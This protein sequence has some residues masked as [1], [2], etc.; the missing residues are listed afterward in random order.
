MGGKVS[1]FFF[2]LCLFIFFVCR[3]LR[4]KIPIKVFKYDITRLNKLHRESLIEK[5]TRH[6]PKQAKQKESYQIKAIIA[7]V[8]IATLPVI[9]CAELDGVYW[10]AHCQVVQ[11][12]AQVGIQRPL[13]SVIQPEVISAGVER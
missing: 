13:T 7:A 6:S 9:V 4:I 3:F 11:V 8:I 1:V 10:N 2:L 12:S 5:W